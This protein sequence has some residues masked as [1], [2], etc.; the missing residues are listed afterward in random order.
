MDMNDKM[1]KRLIVAGGVAACVLVAA[2]IVMR[3]TPAPAEPVP[4]PAA[5]NTPQSEVTVLPVDTDDS[6]KVPEIVIQLPAAQPQSSQP[7]MSGEEQ[8]IQPDVSKPETATQ[9]ESHE[10][11][12]GPANTDPK[13]P[14]TTPQADQPQG[15]ETSAGKIYVPGFGWIDDVGDAKGTE[16]DGEGDINKQVGIMD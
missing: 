10:K 16:V 3:M 13:T 1:K 7:D 9:G 4:L 14:P 2:L 15:G 11:P 5:D 8:S 6:V 12:D